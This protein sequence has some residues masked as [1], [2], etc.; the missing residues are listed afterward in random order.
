MALCR[1]SPSKLSTVPEEAKAGVRQETA[2]CAKGMARA[3][4]PLAAGH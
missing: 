3:E 2:V 4:R 1:E